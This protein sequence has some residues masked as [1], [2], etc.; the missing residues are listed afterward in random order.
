MDATHALNR[1]AGVSYFS[2]F[3]GRSLS[4][5]ATLLMWA[6]LCTDKS[7]LLGKYWRSICL[8]PFKT[9]CNSVSISSRLIRLQLTQTPMAWRASR[10]QISGP[11]KHNIVT[12]SS[13]RG[14]VKGYLS[15]AQSV[16]IATRYF[17]IWLYA[18]YV[19][20]ILM[21]RNTVGSFHTASTDQGQVLRVE[22]LYMEYRIS[23]VVIEWK[24][25][26]LGP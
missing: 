5:R 8:F 21:I 11:R 20:D 1:S 26:L 16:P 4:S 17:W 15:Q 19:C 2:V 12:S 14:C 18:V 25:A 6:R 9:S 3:H 23:H 10:F 7:V 13:V 24:S 22:K